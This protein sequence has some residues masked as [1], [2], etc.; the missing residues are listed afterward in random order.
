MDYPLEELLIKVVYLTLHP[1]FHIQLKTRHPKLQIPI[2]QSVFIIYDFLKLF[3][4]LIQKTIKEKK[5]F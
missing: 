2:L 5:D 4:F 1:I 3:T